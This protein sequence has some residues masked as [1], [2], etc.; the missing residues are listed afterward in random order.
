MLWIQLQAALSDPEHTLTLLVGWF[1]LGILLR[2]ALLGLGKLRKYLEMLKNAQD[3]QQDNT[4]IQKN[5]NI[6]LIMLRN[7]AFGVSVAFIY[8]LLIYTVAAL[9]LNNLGFLFLQGK[10]FII[11]FNNSILQ[12][13]LILFST[14]VVNYLIG[15]FL[16]IKIKQPQFDRKI[17]RAQTINTIVYSTLRVILFVVAFLML[18][19]IVGIDSKSLL[20]GVSIL[21]LAISFG[22][23][24]IIKDLFNGF[25]VILEDH[26]GIDDVVTINNNPAMSGTVE[27]FTLRR[28]VLRALDG[29]M[30]VIP[31][32]QITTASIASKDW[33]RFVAVVEISADA[34]VQ[35]ALN[36]FDQV[37]Q[38]M[39]EDP[40]WQDKCIDRPVIEGVQAFTAQGI[41]L[42]GLFKV[43]PKEQW[44][45]GREF[46]QRI[47][48]AF[49]Q[50]HISFSNQA[51][52][53]LAQ[54]QQQPL[55]VVLRRG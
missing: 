3:L 50:A 30:H 28:T 31:N 29:T 15:N 47:Q 20:A 17:A 24:N 23:N 16:P 48:L 42:R 32:G 14:Y 2:F 26:Y 44:A 54:W 52:Q 39:Y 43:K 27:D 51:Q 35:H 13:F 25:F 53:G 12:I 9:D 36:I 4:G 38:G 49:N 5:I 46:N 22:A 19:P 6:Q 11:W 1:I 45:L 34:D 33:A 7:T 21:G 41:Q 10:K 18:L 55:Q 40:L 8:F 37:A